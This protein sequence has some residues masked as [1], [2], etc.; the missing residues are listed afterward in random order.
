MRP[1]CMIYYKNKCSRSKEENKTNIITYDEITAEELRE[2]RNKVEKFLVNQKKREQSE[3][4]RKYVCV[5][6]RDSYR[7]Q[8]ICWK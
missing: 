8:Q 7:T 4:K 6:V 3:E 5:Y 2:T 1:P